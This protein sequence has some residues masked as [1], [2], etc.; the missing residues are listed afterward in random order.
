MA[1]M[2]GSALSHLPLGVGFPTVAPGQDQERSALCAGY[3]LVWTSSA[4]QQPQAGQVT[5][6]GYLVGPSVPLRETDSQSGVAFPEGTSLCRP[7]TARIVRAALRVFAP[8]ACRASTGLKSKIKS[9]CFP[10]IPVLEC[11]HPKRKRPGFP[12]RHQD[13]TT[14]QSPGQTQNVQPMAPKLALAWSIAVLHWAARAALSV[15][16]AQLLFDCSMPCFIMSRWAS[17]TL[18]AIQ[19]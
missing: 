19:A 5:K 4:L 18:S 15:T 7:E 9:S 3:F 17:G 6:E 11:T 10:C 16:A 12:G 13:S 1:L 14:R 2:L 8:P